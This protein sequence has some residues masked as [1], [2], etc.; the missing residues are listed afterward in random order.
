M[1]IDWAAGLSGATGPFATVAMDVSRH[2]ATGGHETDVR[3]EDHARRLAELGAPD[4]VVTALGATLTSAHGRPGDVGRLAVATAADGVVLDVLLPVPPV[5]E[6]T[7]WGPVPHLLPGVR[8]LNDHASYAVAIVSSGGGEIHLVTP[9]GEAARQEV[10]GDHDV[11]HRVPG[12]GWSQ[13]RYQQRVEDSVA[14]NAA[15]VAQELGRIV[16]A[17]RPDL[18]FVTG[19]EKSVTDLLAQAPAEVTDRAVRIHEGRPDDAIAEAVA[20]WLRDRRAEV[21]DRFASAEARQQEAVQSLP[22]VVAALQRGQVDELLLVDDP[23]SDLE[24]WA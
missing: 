1:R 10:A 14:R 9:F 13:R 24:L 7:Q 2:D 19:Q 6:S 20:S 5:R 8:A 3:W 4:E 12:G 23:S 22:D 15:E 16:R 17:E 11:L 18:V 21:L